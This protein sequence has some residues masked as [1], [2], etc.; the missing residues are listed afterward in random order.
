MLLIGWLPSV[1]RTAS[2][3]ARNV[4]PATARV[5]PS[6]A[7]TPA[8]GLVYDALRSGHLPAG[9]KKPISTSKKPPFGAEN[10]YEI[11]GLGTIWPSWP[12]AEFSQ[13]GSELAAEFENTAFYLS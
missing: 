11:I 1:S 5:N 8:A 12:A 3:E 4:A 7:S 6:P 13:V 10:L 2:F 9:R